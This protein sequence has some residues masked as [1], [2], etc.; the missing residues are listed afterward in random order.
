[1]TTEESAKADADKAM[2]DLQEKYNELLKSSTI[3]NHTARYLA[4]PGYD[5]KLA[6]ETAEALFNGD[7]DKV[8]ENQQKANAA[9][10]KELL[11]EQTRNSPQPKGAGSGETEDPAVLWIIHFFMDNAI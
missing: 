2:Q 7:M 11:A 9:R 4:L 10:E 3:A 5:E 1:M 6:R 8:F